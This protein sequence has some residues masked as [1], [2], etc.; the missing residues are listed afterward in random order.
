MPIATLIAAGASAS[1][2]PIE[3]ARIGTVGYWLGRLS[4]ELDAQAKVTAY[5]TTISP[6]VIPCNSQRPSSVRRSARCSPSSLTIGA[7]LSLTPP[8]SG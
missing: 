3:N 7:R 6:A 1:P 8:L 2:E 5:L 4:V